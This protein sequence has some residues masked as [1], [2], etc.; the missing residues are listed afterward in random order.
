MF[1]PGPMSNPKL[2]Q[3]LKRK[4]FKSSNKLLPGANLNSGDES[5]ETGEDFIDEF[6]DSNSNSSTSSSII[7]ISSGKIALKPTKI[8]HG[9]KIIVTEEKMSDALRDLQIEMDSMPIQ[10]NSNQEQNIFFDICSNSSSGSS[11]EEE[12]NKNSS[13]IYL[14]EELKNKLREYDQQT[15]FLNSSIKH[16]KSV[17]FDLNK[18]QVIPWTPK[19][20]IP[21]SDLEEE[22]SGNSSSSSSET[23]LNSI[24]GDN[25]TTYKVQEPSEANNRPAKN[26]LKRKFSQLN[27]ITIEEIDT[28]LN[29][30]K[31]DSSE[32]KSSFYL[33]DE[34]DQDQDL[35]KNSQYFGTGGRTE[36]PNSS[37]QISEVTD[38][39][40][41][42]MDI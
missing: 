34:T 36:K 31:T 29:S 32:I 38:D 8:K 16:E 3:K 1:S 23:S 10:S 42:K 6:E 19:P 24:S 41:E 11:D 2:K 12:E 35:R 18:M 20:S 17:D 14:S 37:L 28:K 5:S 27:K 26:K 30:T 4:H 21:L 7:S 13:G 25:I 40:E 15:Y 22:N 9:H 33:V 39:E